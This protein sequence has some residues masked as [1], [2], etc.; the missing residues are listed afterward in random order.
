MSFDISAIAKLQKIQELA[1]LTPEVKERLFRGMA[2]IV[3]EDIERRFVVSPRTTDGGNVYPL[4]VFWKALSESYLN[5][6]PERRK[7]QIYID[8]GTTRDSLIKENSNGNITNIDTQN[9]ILEVG[10]SLSHVP[11]LD[12]ARKIYVDHIELRQKLQEYI[13]KFISEEMTK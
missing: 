7:G 3:R 2:Q 10:S 11:K 1:E 13:Q 5:K 6:H 4:T 12:A 8:T 9:N